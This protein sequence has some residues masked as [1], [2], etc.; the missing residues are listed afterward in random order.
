MKIYTKTGDKG[1]TSL[2]DGTRVK[3]SNVRVDTY[4][5]IDELNSVIGVILAQNS[6][7]K[8]RD[9]KVTKELIRVQNDLLEIG[10]SL[11]NPSAILDSGAKKYFTKRVSSFEQFIDEMTKEMPELNQFILPSGGEAGS[12]LHVGRTIARKVERKLVGL[13]EQ[14]TVDK[15]ILVYF[16]RLSDLLFT[17]SRFANFLEKKKETIW[18]KRT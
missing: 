10:S 16:N 1:L 11:A 9:A 18:I 12:F 5:T 7:L 3:K 6:G 15:E 14:E 4:G 8:S 13:M 17:M 2:F